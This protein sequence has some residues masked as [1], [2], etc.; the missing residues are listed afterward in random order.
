M[1]VLRTRCKR[2]YDAGTTNI[3]R[4][5]NGLQTKLGTTAFA[6]SCPGDGSSAGTGG[7]VAIPGNSLEEEPSES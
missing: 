2:K 1:C 3:C 5:K 4:P 7:T 6:K